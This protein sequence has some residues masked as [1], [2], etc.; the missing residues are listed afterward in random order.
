MHEFDVG[1]YNAL[2]SN[3]PQL[4]TMIKNII[5][6][7]FMH[8]AELVIAHLALAR[9]VLIESGL[10]QPQTAVKRA[11]TFKSISIF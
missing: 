6:F 11:P 3:F 4:G 9:P 8:V 1:S 5:T 2:A 10:Y 7:V